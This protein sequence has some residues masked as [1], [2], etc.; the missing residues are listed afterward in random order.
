MKLTGKVAFRDLETGIW[1]LEADD[2]KTY[3]LAGGDRKIKK[4]GA[5]IEADGD[6]DADSVTFAM[7]GP[8]FVVRQYRFV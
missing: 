8:R 3:L 2:G 1:V 7:I 6:L 4:S 5:R